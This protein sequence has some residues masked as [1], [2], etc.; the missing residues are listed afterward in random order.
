VVVVAVVRAGLAMGAELDGP[1]QRAFAAA[2]HVASGAVFAAMAGS[3]VVIVL[4]F[5]ARLVGGSR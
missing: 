1:G 3:A 2:T 5:G 4:V